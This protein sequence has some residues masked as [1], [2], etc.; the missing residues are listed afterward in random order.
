MR[1]LLFR[2]LRAPDG[3]GGGGEGGGGAGAGGGAGDGG[4]ATV[5]GGEGGAAAGGADTI[6]GGAGDPV[7]LYRPDGLAEQYRGESDTQTIDK[8]MAAVAER[9]ADVPE[10]IAA[11][12]DHGEVSDEL[13]PYYATLERDGLFDA[14]ASK[15]KD[16]GVGKAQLQG[17]L[18]AYMTGA[19]EMGLLEPP[20]DV[21]A[22]RGALLPDSARSLPKAEQDRAI[23]Q[24]M[25]DNL[26]W[27]EKM[28]ERGLPADS[29][30]HMAL[31]LGDTA[32]GHKAIEFFRSQ[33]GRADEARPAGSGGGG[34]GNSARGDLQRRSELPENTPGHQKFSRD[35]YDQLQRDYQSAFPD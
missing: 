31:M 33:M 15:A 30:K 20:I 9:S 18:Q 26:G 17:I 25:N 34:G 5:A 6:A 7:Q 10:D 21:S 27:V 16:L 3:E 8:L 23:D 11:Y 14:V 24:R 12:R 19:Q 4:A 22:E 13:K 2:I 32:D 28:V 1:N 29:A 35:S